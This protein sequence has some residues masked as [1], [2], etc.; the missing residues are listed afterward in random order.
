MKAE[1]G[2]T[3]SRLEPDGIRGETVTQMA[4]W[5]YYEGLGC[6]VIADR[7]NADL[8]RYPPPEAP[9]KARTR[10]TWSRSAVYH[11]LSNPKYTG[12]QVFN[13]RATT[14]KRG[15]VNEPI[16]WVWSPQPIHEPLIPKWMFDAINAQRATRDGNQLH[17]HPQTRRTFLFRGRVIHSC[18]RR[19]I[20][21]TKHNRLFYYL[22][23]PRKN[24]RGGP[25]PHAGLPTAIRI[26]EDDLLDAV[27]RFYADR[28]FGAHRHTILAN[29]LAGFD[30]HA[31]RERQTERER[32]QRQLADVAK[33]Q[34]AVMRQAQ[35]GD[36]DDPFAKALRQTYNDLEGQKNKTQ[37]ALAQ[38]AAQDA[39]EPDRPKPADLEL[40]D[41]LP[42]LTANPASAP[43]PL[44]RGTVSKPLNSRT[45][46]ATGQ[47]HAGSATYRTLGV[48]GG[49]APG[50]KNPSIPPGVVL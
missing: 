18:G 31:A 35:A 19:M 46:T 24:N 37:S 44:L 41:A 36:P 45:S 29:D 4:L 23:W 33:R 50:G 20:G 22:C 48:G 11:I 16:K 10:G 13:R 7:L 6:G 26:R 28:V 17:K 39:T 9:S 2:R 43:P 15:K 5:R 38:L 21:D 1:K 3:K 40:L 32:F 30:D 8:Q 34:D 47:D 12:Y 25:D 27:A 14:S 49:G 42:Y